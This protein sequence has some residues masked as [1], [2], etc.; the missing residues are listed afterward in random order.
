ME[1][2]KLNLSSIARIPND[3]GQR[4]RMIAELPKMMS[5]GAEVFDRVIKTLKET[6]PN[7]DE[8]VAS[9]VF[10]SDITWV[11]DGKTDATITIKLDGEVIHQETK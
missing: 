2:Y 10:Y 3:K 9:D 6:S 7:L 11:D 8:A 5:A 1:T 4:D